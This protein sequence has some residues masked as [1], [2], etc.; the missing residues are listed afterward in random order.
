MAA[1][2][3]CHGVTKSGSPTPSEITP[4]WLWTMSKNSR[5]PERGMSRTFFATNDSELN[6]AAMCMRANPA[7]PRG[8]KILSGSLVLP[9]ANDR[10]RLVEHDRARNLHRNDVIGPGDLIHNIEHDLF[11]NPAQRPR[12]GAFADCH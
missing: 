1:S 2:R 3:M 7:G 10:L 11:E 12:P 5:I 6:G 4:F 9:A 8:R